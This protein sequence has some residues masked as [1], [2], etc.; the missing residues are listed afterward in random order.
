[1]INIVILLT[2]CH[3]GCGGQAVLHISETAQLVLYGSP[4]FRDY[5]TIQPNKQMFDE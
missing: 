3:G 1:M 5:T 2:L 4:I